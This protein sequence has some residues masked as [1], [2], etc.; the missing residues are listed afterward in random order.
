[1]MTITKL[2]VARRAVSTLGLLLGA[3]AANAMAQS[4][5]GSI[6]VGPMFAYPELE[7]AVKRDSNIAIVPD[8][9]RKADTIW[10]LRPSVRLEA[11][12]GVNLYDVTYRGEYGRYDSQKTDN[13]NNHD[14]AARSNMTFDARNNLK[15]GLQ[16]QDKVDPRGTLNLVATPT[17]NEWRQPS[18]TGLY[19]YGAEDAQGKLELQGG[20]LDKRY[21]NNRFA[22]SVLDHSQTDY[23]G[24][25]LWKALPKTYATFNLRQSVFDYKDN[26]PLFLDSKNTYA[27]VGARWE[28]TAAT[29][30]RFALGNVTK[31]FDAAGHDFGRQDRSGLGWEGG[32]NWKPRSY[33]SV[34]LITQ[35]MPMD[36][37]GLGDFTINETYQVLWTHAWTSQFSSILTGSYSTDK[38]SNAPIAAAGGADREDTTKSAGLRLTY[39]MQRWLK[40]GAEYLYTVRDSNDNNFDY[41]RNQLMFFVSGTL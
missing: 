36:S 34:D 19:T 29:S 31:K 41:K 4:P 21:V 18:A 30:G 9:L 12:Q 11:K 15:L 22:T 7:V 17:P 38:F 16:Y 1:M 40:L 14:L 6:P 3:L 5:P 20:Y 25:F 24:T 27:L 37:T 10:Y 28:A 32:I 26:A 2:L 35:H 23:G 33:S 39:S 8:A 13:F